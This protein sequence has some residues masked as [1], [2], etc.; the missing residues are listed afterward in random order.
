MTRT[1]RLTFTFGQ[2]K[3]TLPDMGVSENR[4]PLY[5]TL[6]GRILIIRPPKWGTPDYPPRFEDHC[7]SRL[8][9]GFRLFAF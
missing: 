7:L 4:G 9:L 5:G 1:P 2:N 3:I 6:N 8:R